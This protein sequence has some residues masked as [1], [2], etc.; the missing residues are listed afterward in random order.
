MKG[1]IYSLALLMGAISANAQTLTDEQVSE[2]LINKEAIVTSA[3]TEA[4]IEYFFISSGV[5]A[6]MPS[7][8]FDIYLQTNGTIV[9]NRFD[10]KLEDHQTLCGLILAR[11]A[12]VDESYARPIVAAAFDT[13]F[14]GAPRPQALANALVVVKPQAY[15]YD[16]WVGEHPA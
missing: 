11:T 2:I 14:K 7:D 8:E 16:C 13:M 10:G 9:R 6:K 1:L 5:V 15:G 4:R 3:L 12:N